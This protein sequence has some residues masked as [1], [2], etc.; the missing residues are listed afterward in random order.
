MNKRMVSIV[1]GILV[2]G[3]FLAA[4]FYLFP[5]LEISARKAAGAGWTEAK[6]EIKGNIL[7]ALREGFVDIDL[8]QD[9]M[10][11]VATCV[12][13]QIVEF[14]NGTDC[15]Y[16]YNESTTSEAEHLKAQE[17][18]LATIGYDAKEIEFTIEC[19]KQHVPKDWNIMRPLLSREMDAALQGQILDAAKRKTAVDCVVGQTVELLGKTEC[20]PLNPAAKTP[21]QLFTPADE[22]FENAGIKAQAE[23][24]IGACIA[25]AITE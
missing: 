13:D 1:L 25:P 11:K 21:E 9:V 20:A 4:K 12:T 17:A 3:G 5:E 24:A 7:S 19:A 22:C 23:E 15:D 16:Y 8:R 2:A 18:C 6:P 10:D 14:L